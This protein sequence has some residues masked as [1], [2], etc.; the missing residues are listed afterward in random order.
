M[1]SLIPEPWRN[2]YIYASDNRSAV[3]GG[4]W[5]AEGLTN[6]NLYFM[7]EVFCSFA[8]TFSLCDDSE[9]LIERDGQQLQPGNYYIVT[10]GECLL[11]LHH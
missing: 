5:A 2:T 3:L 1:P 11:C 8:D 7:L 6:A 10:A 4:I 9:R